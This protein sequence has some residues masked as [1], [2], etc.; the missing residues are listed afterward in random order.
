MP[1]TYS[2]NRKWV[3]KSWD[4]FLLPCPFAKAVLIY[5]DS[6]EVNGNS[7]REDKR[8]ELERKLMAITGEADTY[9]L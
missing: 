9:Y 7:N 5:G 4:R 3:L 6:V 8:L 1:L 2:A